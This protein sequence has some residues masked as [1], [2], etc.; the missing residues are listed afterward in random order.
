VAGLRARDFVR[1][2]GLVSLCRAPLAAAFPFVFRDAVAAIALMAAAGL[3]DLLDG[4][5]AR[6]FHQETPTGAVLD[7]AMDKVFALSVLITLVLGRLLSPVDAL[8]LSLR[9]VIEALILVAALALRPRPTDAHRP[10]NALGK[11]TSVFQFATVMLVI[12]KRGPR[13]AGVYATGACGA[14]TALAYGWREFQGEQPH[15]RP[16]GPST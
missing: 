16:G 8:V 5:I 12:L 11:M 3:T 1:V 14:V 9:E 15:A 13:L 2:P 6:N 10:S 4:W 7:G